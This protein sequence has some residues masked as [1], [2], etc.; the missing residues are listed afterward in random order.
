MKIQKIDLFEF[1]KLVDE[2]KQF[3]V[4]FKSEGCHLC[5][6]LQPDYETLADKFYPV[7][8]YDVDVDEEEELASL[9][10][11]DGVPTIYH[12]EGKCFNE[13]EYP[14]KG[15]E[16]KSLLKILKKYIVGDYGK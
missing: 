1:K 12:I 5:T 8:F 11:E 13:L 15:Y 14:E 7:P 10:I 4:K 16:K 3:I 2:N 6:E 9:F